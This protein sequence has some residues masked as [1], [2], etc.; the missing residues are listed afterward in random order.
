MS[1]DRAERS[2]PAWL[3]AAALALLTVT[4]FAV[5]LHHFTKN[6]EPLGSDGYYYVVQV[7]DLIT[8][9]RLHVPDGSWVLHWLALCGWAVD[10]QI[11]GIKV[12][13]AFLAAIC[14]PAAWWLGRRAAP[15]S[16]AAW[17]LASWA[18]ASPTLTQ[19]GGEFTKNIGMAA[20]LLILLG[21]L[22]A[23]L[24]RSRWWHHALGAVALMAAFSAHR[25]GAGLGLLA[26]VGASAGWLTRSERGARTGLLV[27]GGGLVCFGVAAAWLPNLLH[28]ADLERLSGQLRLTPGIPSPFGY[29]SLR[30]TTAAQLFELSAAWLALGL[31]LFTWWRG[32]GGRL[33]HRALLGAAA[34]PLAACLF[35]WWRG[36][37]LDVGYR[38]ALMTPLLTA[39]LLAAALPLPKLTRR[40]AVAAAIAAAALALWAPSQGLDPL[41]TPPYD[42]YRALIRRIPR[43]LPELL[44]AHSGINFLYDHETGEEAMAWAPEP[45]LDRTHIGRI[46]FGIHASEWIDLRR[47]HPDLTPPVFLDADH[48]YV[49][50]DTWEALLR[51]APRT[52]AWQNPTRL[53]PASL[54]RNR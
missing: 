3:T 41:D 46:T 45:E 29:V 38:L 6:P 40:S 23:D 24:E 10:S 1:A 9:G 53:R 39:P 34:L 48:A 30:A 54:L 18:A 11:L 21:W 4:A 25:L 7:S 50:E 5:R 19:L 36:D 16:W 33:P 17:F 49:R 15:H 37:V 20:P 26:L 31:A 13:A 22:A 14:V 12:G 42:H 2:V 43:P 28:P 27:A 44:I 32:R 47:H 52:L 8:L 35:P 51:H